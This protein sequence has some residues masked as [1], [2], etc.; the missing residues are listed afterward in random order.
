MSSSNAVSRCDSTADVLPTGL[1][2][3]KLVVQLVQLAVLRMEVAGHPVAG[4]GDPHGA[5]LAAGS[6]S[7]RRL[8]G[9][10]GRRPPG[11]RFVEP[12]EVGVLALAGLDEPRARRAAP[13]MAVE[14]TA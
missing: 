3:Q 9:H 11:P 2:H 13:E 12:G 4:G 7:G 14:A 10:L 5:T 1:H 8:H 6:A